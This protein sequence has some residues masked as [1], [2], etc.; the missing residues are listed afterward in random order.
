MLHRHDGPVG[1]QDVGDAARRRA[2]TQ[3]RRPRIDLVLDVTVVLTYI[4]FV[5]WQMGV[6]EHDNVG[7]REP[8]PE[9][10]G[11]TGGWPAVV[12]HGDASAVNVDRQ[13]LGKLVEGDVVV[14]P[15]RVDT[16]VRHVRC[17][18]IE[19]RGVGDVA[20]VED[21]IGRPQLARDPLD[22]PVRLASGE[23]SVGDGQD[24]RPNRT[25]ATRHAG[26]LP[27]AARPRPGL[28]P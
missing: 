10:L 6:P 5:P 28:R 27:A 22:Q 15:H 9:P 12:N 26:S 11:P 4:G 20:G 14:A 3:H 18:S 8:L 23:M 17:Q 13:S 25:A 7:I 24:V 16:A 21:Q 2:P 19:D 1:D